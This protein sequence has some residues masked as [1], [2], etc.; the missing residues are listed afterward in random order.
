METIYTLH[1]E[2][3]PS[4][5]LTIGYPGKAHVFAAADVMRNAWQS[6]T[7]THRTGHWY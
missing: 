1:A 6:V 2:R 4:G 7:I 3:E 5:R